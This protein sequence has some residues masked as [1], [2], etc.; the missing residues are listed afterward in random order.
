MCCVVV[1]SILSSC[2]YDEDPFP[3][4][5]G[6][7][8]QA[9]YMSFRISARNTSV[10][11]TKSRSI[12]PD[13]GHSVKWG[14]YYESSK[15]V[16]FEDRILKDCFHVTFYDSTDKHY[17]GCLENIYC[18]DL[19][20][21]GTDDVYEFRGVLQFPI[22][23]PTLEQLRGMSVRMNITANI[24][25]I[26]S[27]RLQSSQNDLGTVV[28]NFIGQE[29]AFPAIPMWGVSTCPLKGIAPG[30]TLNMGSVSMLRAMAKIEVCV[31]RS[32]ENLADVTINNVC[33]NRTNSSGY[34][35][36]KAWNTVEKTDSLKFSETLRVPADSQGESRVFDK[37]NADKSSVIFYLPECENSADSEIIMTVN[38][39]VGEEPR[40]GEIRLCP[41]SEG[42]PKGAPLWDIVRNHHYCYEITNVSRN[43]D[44]DL[45]FKVTIADMEKG[46]DY[47][48]DY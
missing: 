15:A 28:Y 32:N 39:M 27:D 30:Q 35:L 45:R 22:P 29:N 3:G 26:T 21:V 5:I 7:D 34:G 14:D 36:P 48:F 31:D 12:S 43:S 2:I 47:V 46:G 25:G 9:L 18:T 33:I 10:M 16:E 38:Y 8:P 40:T 11:T 23:S 6:T 20:Q 41:Y 37:T 4:E 1:C 42:K 17:V 24:P 19:T 44:E 13:D